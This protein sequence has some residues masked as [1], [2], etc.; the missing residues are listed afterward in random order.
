MRT[1]ISRI[2]ADF[3]D[4]S[5]AGNDVPELLIARLR[6]PPSEVRSVKSAKIREIRVLVK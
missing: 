2:F 4:S 5:A 3:T 6:A 1:R